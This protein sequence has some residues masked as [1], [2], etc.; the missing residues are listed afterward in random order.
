MLDARTAPGQIFLL[1]PSAELAREADR[2][3]T[4]EH[5]RSDMH[6]IDVQTFPHRGEETNPLTMYRPI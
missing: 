3:A 1:G 4:H 5:R 2:W 6:T